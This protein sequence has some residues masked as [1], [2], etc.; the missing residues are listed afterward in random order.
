MPFTTLPSLHKLYYVLRTPTGDN[1]ASLTF[2]F[3]HGLGS[4]SS[5]YAPVMP[6]LVDAGYQCVAFDM[7]GSSL[8]KYSG[9]DNSIQDHADDAKALL[10]ALDIPPAK[11]V[12]VGHSMGGLVAGTLAVEL[13][14]AGAVLIGVVTPSAA[15]STAFSQRIGVVDQDGMEPMADTVPTGATGSASTPT[16]HAF[17]RALLLSQSPQGY[18][19]LCRAIA[20]AKPPDY[21]R[22]QCAA[23]VIAG[24]DD[25]VVPIDGLQTITSSWGAGASLK[26]L[27]GVGHWHCIEA[28]DRVGPLL[29][30]FARTLA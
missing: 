17:I 6:A 3:I 7:N 19:G 14:L 24:A 27:D 9:K 15:I 16:H 11:V 1:G 25:K 10:Q 22:A 28:G 5:F 20:D 29:V 18:V 2:L 13:S 30:D 12:A 21:S 26:V 23:L 8:T 4:S